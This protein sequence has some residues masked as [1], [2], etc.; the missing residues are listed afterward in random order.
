[1]S[2]RA[3]TVKDFASFN[4]GETRLK[5]FRTTDINTLTLNSKKNAVIQDLAVNFI[6]ASQIV[7][8]GTLTTTARSTIDL[9]GVVSINTEVYVLTIEQLEEQLKIAETT[10]GVS[11]TMGPGTFTIT[12][13]LCVPKDTDIRGS[14]Q[15]TTIFRAV[16][17]L[18]S[19]I[20]RI[21]GDN[22]SVYEI[23]FDGNGSNQKRNTNFPTESFA[24]GIHVAGV[25][26]VVI[27][28]CTFKGIDYPATLGV[29]GARVHIQLQEGT[30]DV[31]ITN[32]T[33]G[34][35]VIATNRSSSACINYDL[36][37]SGGIDNVEISNCSFLNPYAVILHFISFVTG[38]AIAGSGTGEATNT[39]VQNLT[40]AN[41]D[42]FSAMGVPFIDSFFSTSPFNQ[43]G[44]EVFGTT[45]FQVNRNIF[46]NGF[47]NRFLR[48]NKNLMQDNN[49][50]RSPITFDSVSAP[51][52]G[53]RAAT[54]LVEIPSTV[55]GSFS[56]HIKISNNLID[57]PTTIQGIHVRQR[58]V[59]FLSIPFSNVL[60]TKNLITR[61][62]SVTLNIN[63][64]M[65][66]DPV[67]NP[68]RDTLAHRS[69][70][71]N[72]SILERTLGP[73]SGAV[74][75]DGTTVVRANT[76]NT[77]ANF[78]LELQEGDII[79]IGGTTANVG[80][81]ANNLFFSTSVAI[82]SGTDQGITVTTYNEINGLDDIYQLT[83]TGS[84]G[85]HT[86]TL[87]NT[88]PST[89]G[90]HIVIHL[91]EHGGAAADDVTIT[92]TRTGIVMPTLTASYTSA[93]LN[94]ANDYVTFEWTGDLWDI[95]ATNGA[96]I[97]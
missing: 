69:V 22:V 39:I 35:E 45:N 50:S 68:N 26:N 53:F 19:E 17:N 5:T 64:P 1:M 90:H 71:R 46:R 94:S 67:G 12:K 92:P 81:I 87:Q 30:S 29:V 77:A 8:N 48:N 85:P 62:N 97:V 89:A 14:G 91:L 93:T 55:A 13:T 75:T 20:M 84:N 21:K 83:T 11:I 2:F 44:F 60:V 32:C 65:E 23:Q 82:P 25:N 57:D 66:F 3:G 18:N 74:D 33:F 31:R 42:E 27:Q 10:G 76:A 96:T 24:H 34:P 56:K 51:V 41:S 9:K 72:L 37:G 70:G 6:D 43:S 80:V 40:T 95:K 86:L 52:T 47:I 63:S 16:D 49:L 61:N 36:V 38:I 59:G 73:I 88:Y 4:S 28:S 78:L 15:N 58:S 7:L 79:D 54:F